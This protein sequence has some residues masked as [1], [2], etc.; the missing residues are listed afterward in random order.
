MITAEAWS[1]KKYAVYG[2]ARSGL[3]TVR[4][5]V[6]SGAEVTAWD[7]R[8]EAR[9][10]LRPSPSGEVS[11]KA[12]EGSGKPLEKNPSLSSADPSPQGEKLVL[13]EAKKGDADQ[14]VALFQNALASVGG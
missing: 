10:Q 1:N 14:L 3:A 6:A 4:A 5:L 11:P 9:N 12:A 2:L 8:E 13:R 7:D